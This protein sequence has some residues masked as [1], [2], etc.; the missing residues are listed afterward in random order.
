MYMLNVSG[1]VN[2]VS[3]SQLNLLI[4]DLDW[5]KGEW[6]WDWDKGLTIFIC[7]ESI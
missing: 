4:W 5:V 7:P 3:K 6:D 1:L 2:L